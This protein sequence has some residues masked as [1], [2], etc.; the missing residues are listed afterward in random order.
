[1][2]DNI[3]ANAVSEDQEIEMMPWWGYSKEHGWVVLDRRIPVN[4][5]GRKSDL[6]FVRCRDATIIMEKRESWTPPAYRF[7]PNHIRELP[8]PEAEEAAAELEALKVRWPEFDREIQRAW[9]EKEERAQ[10][11]RVA[12]ERAGKLA[13]AE[14]KKQ[15]AAAKR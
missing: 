4:L 7:A 2:T 10:A 6:L 14:K 11:A 12:E 13:A 8:S 15:A 1:M 3:R 9:R 5:P